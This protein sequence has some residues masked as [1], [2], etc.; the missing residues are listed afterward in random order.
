MRN[1][2]LG[3]YL[4]PRP[5]D[6]NISTQHIPTLLAQ[7]LQ[8]PAKRSQHL[9]ATD[10]NVGCNLLR[11]FGHHVAMC[12]GMLRVE[13]RTSAYALAQHCCTLNLAKRLQHRATSTNVAWKIWSFSNLSH[14]T[15]PNTSQQ[16]GQTHATFST[17]QCCDMLRWDVAFVWP[18]AA[19]Q[20]TT[21]LFDG[22]ERNQLY[23]ALNS[24]KF[25]QTT[26]IPT[27]CLSCVYLYYR[28][29]AFLN[30]FNNTWK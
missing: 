26:R 12:C 27:V 18:G 14:A 22:K 10:C 1:A 24:R 19:E 16:D 8:A 30:I 20:L 25:A 17:Q 28:A 7:H 4:K 5:N 13:N 15:T 23:C 2:I 11:A 29:A 21:E 6:G 9:N 3:N